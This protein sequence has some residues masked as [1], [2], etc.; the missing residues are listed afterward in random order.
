MSRAH[1]FV[2]SLKIMFLSFFLSFFLS[3]LIHLLNLFISSLFVCFLLL[4]FFFFLLLI[5]CS[6]HLPL[7]WNSVPL[8]LQER[9][10]FST[11]YGIGNLIYLLH[12]LLV[13]LVKMSNVC[14]ACC[15]CR[16]KWKDLSC[17]SSLPIKVV[18]CRKPQVMSVIMFWRAKRA[19]RDNTLTTVKELSLS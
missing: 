6:F 7:L 9:R 14:T 17:L 13:E 10:K 11:R 4:I 18:F 16:N 5:C 15:I 12:E 19:I 3:S 1:G 2:I 8:T